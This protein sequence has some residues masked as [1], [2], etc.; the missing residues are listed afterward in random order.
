MPPNAHA[1]PMLPVIRRTRLLVGL[2]LVL[3]LSALI[4]GATG[5]Q[6]AN[7]SVATPTLQR[8]ATILPGG[9]VSIHGEGFSPGGMVQIVF[10]IQ[11]DEASASSSH[12]VI[13]NAAAY[14]P[15]GTQDP[16]RGYVPAGSFTTIV[17]LDAPAIHGPNGS[18]DPAQGYRPATGGGNILNAEDL[19]VR[20][21]D[22]Q[23]G[24]WSN[25]VAV[26]A[27]LME[28]PV[29]SIIRT[30]PRSCV[31]FIPCYLP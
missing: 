9:L 5:P 19:R 8:V 1:Y 16:A 12:W 21:F 28:F 18:Q 17:D 3:L 4:P 30:L 31:V 22:H 11:G 15:H 29:R 13:A 27:T 2:T 24:Y 7:A 23:T 14:G 25:L 6:T 26:D 10:V 20:A